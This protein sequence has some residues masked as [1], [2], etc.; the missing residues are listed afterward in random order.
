MGH[1][2]KKVENHWS[3]T[4]TSLKYRRM[5]RFQVVTW[6]F[7]SSQKY[8][9]TIDFWN[10]LPHLQTRFQFNTGGF[11]KNLLKLLMWNAR[12]RINGRLHA[13]GVRP[14]RHFGPIPIFFIADNPHPDIL[15][16]SNHMQRAPQ[17]ILNQLTNNGNVSQLNKNTQKCIFFCKAMS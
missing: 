6:Q 12:P 16:F 4:T 10:D 15:H 9:I 1:G 3:R 2:T 8:Q 14:V 5:L 7:D 11:R 13:S 17:S